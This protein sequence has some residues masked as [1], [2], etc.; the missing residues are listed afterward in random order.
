MLSFKKQT[1][2]MTMLLKGREKTTSA[3][4]KCQKRTT[5][6]YLECRR[7]MNMVKMAYYNLEGAMM[8]QTEEKALLRTV[9]RPNA[10]RNLTTS[11]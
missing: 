11:L 2:K 6:F 9:K 10:L 3:N 8:N 1:T 7:E 4:F 5:L